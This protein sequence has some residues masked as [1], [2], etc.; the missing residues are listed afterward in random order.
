M[1]YCT[2]C[3]QRNPA[4]PCPSPAFFNVIEAF[5]RLVFVL[6]YFAYSYRTH[7]SEVW[8][9]FG[10]DLSSSEQDDESETMELRSLF[11]MEGTE[12]THQFERPRR[13][14][15]ND[16]ILIKQHVMAV[17]EGLCVRRLVKLSN[18]SN[19]VLQFRVWYW[20]KIFRCLATPRD[21]QCK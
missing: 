2:T 10:P 4:L 13:V 20:R 8:R 18:A 17:D 16:V 15:L 3:A 1:D 5:G 19:R 12:K 6:W 14:L 7:E 11:K 21:Y 9:N